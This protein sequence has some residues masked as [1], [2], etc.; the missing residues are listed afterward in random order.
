MSGAVPTPAAVFV[1]IDRSRSKGN[2]KVR[3]TVPNTSVISNCAMLQIIVRDMAATRRPS[4]TYKIRP[5]YSPMRLGV[6]DAIVAPVKIALK[7][8]LNETPPSGRM[9]SCHFRA[10]MP[11]LTGMSRRI[12]K[13][14]HQ[15]GPFE[16]PPDPDR[17]KS[18]SRV[19]G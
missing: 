14:L 16:R 11:Q 9:A 5:R 13:S 4:F 2:R 8:S 6:K 12:S 7:A 15:P 18:A 19:D 17:V 10:S 3:P 1:A